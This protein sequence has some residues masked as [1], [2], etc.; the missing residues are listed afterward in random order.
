MSSPEETVN[1]FPLPLGLVEAHLGAFTGFNDA[2][3]DMIA[4]SNEPEERINDA[5]PLGHLW[6]FKEDT[7][8]SHLTRF[9]NDRLSYQQVLPP[10]R[11]Y[12]A[13]VC[14]GDI[15]MR[16]REDQLVDQGY[17]VD[18]VRLDPLRHYLLLPEGER[19]DE[20]GRFRGE[21]FLEDLTRQYGATAVRHGYFEQDAAV[22]ALAALRDGWQQ[23]EMQYLFPTAEDPANFFGEL[24]RGMFQLLRLYKIGEAEATVA[25]WTD[26]S[27]D[28]ARHFIT[29]DRETVPDIDYF[30][31]F[32]RLSTDTQLAYANGTHGE[33]CGYGALPAGAAAVAI[34]SYLIGMVPA[35]PGRL[36]EVGF[37]RSVRTFELGPDDALVV[38]DAAD[39]S[40]LVRYPFVSPATD[41]EGLEPTIQA[42]CRDGRTIPL[43]SPMSPP[44]DSFYAA[45][46]EAHTG[47]SPL[48]ELGVEKVKGGST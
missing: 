20:A 12:R 30:R 5:S 34:R 37:K 42:L 48:Y 14:L 4:R 36:M 6:D 43:Y 31:K 24:C 47:T 15:L 3:L 27:F 2:Q 38:S 13:A 44:H 28:A 29:G 17:A 11:A 8:F 26:S 21:R 10:M 25:P 45:I 33:A 22:E 9:T 18:P 7:M 41:P 46:D 16:A 40:E 23:S 39:V 35:A 32:R 19:G 1:R